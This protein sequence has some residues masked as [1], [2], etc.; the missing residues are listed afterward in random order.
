MP[1]IILPLHKGHSGELELA[2]SSRTHALHSLFMHLQIGT[3]VSSGLIVSLSKRYP[4]SNESKIPLL[5]RS[6][7]PKLQHRKTLA[8]SLEQL[9]SFKQIFSIPTLVD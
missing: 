8:A 4:T 5:T 7:S 3:A 6:N 2:I 1:R 9:A